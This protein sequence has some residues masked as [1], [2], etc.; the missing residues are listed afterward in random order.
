M[1]DLLSGYNSGNIK[2]KNMSLGIW[3]LG[4]YVDS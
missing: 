2:N 3:Y 1:V 4:D